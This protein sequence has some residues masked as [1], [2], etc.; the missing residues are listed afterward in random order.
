[1]AISTCLRASS[2]LACHLEL[3]QL[4]WKWSLYR[5]WDDLKGEAAVLRASVAV[6]KDLVLRYFQLHGGGVDL[7]PVARRL[8]PQAVVSA[9]QVVGDLP[10]VKVTLAGL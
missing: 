4:R 10:A 8:V 3:A 1:M 9:K 2:L 7:R 5:F 6:V